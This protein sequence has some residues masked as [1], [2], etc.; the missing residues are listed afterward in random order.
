MTFKDK[1]NLQL[2][3]L[4]YGVGTAVAKFLVRRVGSGSKIH[5]SLKYWSPSRI[6]IDE[7]CEI[8]QGVFL[9]ARSPQ[10]IAISIGEGTRIKDFVGIAA[11]GGEVII[12]KNVLIGR[13]STIF[14]HGGVFIGDYAMVGPNTI[15]VSSN[16]LPYLT[17]TPFQKQG[18]TRQSIHI[19]RNVWIGA[20]V[21]ILG[22]SWIKSDVVVGAGS[23]VCGRLES[24][25]LYRGIPA[26]KIK[27][28]PK[29]KPKDL[30]AY[31]RNWDLFK[32]ECV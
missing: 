30:E 19:E 4:Q 3:S 12:G 28:L 22:G 1:I 17:G 25:W 23:T 5:S 20:N 15:I 29:H 6:C 16:H 11:Y 13:C 21:T 10:K 18:F 9:D 24:G 7:R 26:T 31:H 14:G 2:T 8:R 27:E 32:M